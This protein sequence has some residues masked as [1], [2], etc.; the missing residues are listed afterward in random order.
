M[1]S[2]RRYYWVLLQCRSRCYYNASGTR[3][4]P[5]AL[6]ACGIHLSDLCSWQPAGV[7][8]QATAPSLSSCPQILHDWC[9][10]VLCFVGTFYPIKAPLKA[11]CSVLAGTLFL[12]Q[13]FLE[14]MLF[15]FSF[16]CETSEDRSFLGKVILGNE[17]ELPS[18]CHCLHI[19]TYTRNL[20]REHYW[21]CKA[22]YSYFRKLL[23]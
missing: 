13:T 6:R 5:M 19:Y 4:H 2:V 20:L 1:L 15:L 21:G 10:A 8:H 7:F 14:L 11:R 18:I 17:G 16:L 3:T 22:E 9:F 23:Y 12:K